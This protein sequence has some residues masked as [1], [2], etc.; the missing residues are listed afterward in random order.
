MATLSPTTGAA[1]N[2]AIGKK[3]PPDEP[4]EPI[5]KRMRKIDDQVAWVPG[6]AIFHGFS[7]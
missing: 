1:V 5:A 6:A 2:A 4:A 3:R 7:D